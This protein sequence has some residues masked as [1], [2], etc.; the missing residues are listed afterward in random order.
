VVPS[1]GVRPLFVQMLDWCL[2]AFFETPL[3]WDAKDFGRVDA[4]EVYFG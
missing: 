4:W 1:S 2:L 3:G